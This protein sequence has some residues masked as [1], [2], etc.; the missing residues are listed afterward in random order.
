MSEK[1]RP[2]SAAPRV[3]LFDSNISDKKTSVLQA[4]REKVGNESQITTRY[5]NWEEEAKQK[6]VSDLIKEKVGE[7]K[8]PEGFF[9]SA[10]TS[11]KNVGDSTHFQKLKKF[12]GGLSMPSIKAKTYFGSEARIQFFDR[13]HTIQRQR[14]IITTQQTSEYS[15]PPEDIVNADNSEDYAFKP[16]RSDLPFE[17]SAN[18][19]IRTQSSI[20]EG[21]QFDSHMKFVVKNSSFHSKPAMQAT[22]EGS[23][24]F[25]DFTSSV[26]EISEFN[27][28]EDSFEIRLHKPT[29]DL[30]RSNTLFSPLSTSTLTSP[31]MPMPMPTA[32]RGKRPSTSNSSAMNRRKSSYKGGEAAAALSSIGNEAGLPAAVATLDTAKS[33]SKAQTM[34]ANNINNAAINTS[35][36]SSTSFRRNSS[37]YSV[38][39]DCDNFSALSAIKERVT[40]GDS[41]ASDSLDF[42]LNQS[43]DE[44]IQLVCVEDKRRRGGSIVRYKGRRLEQSSMSVSVGRDMDMDAGSVTSMLVNCRNAQGV[45]SRPKSTNPRRRGK[46]GSHSPERNID[47]SSMSVYNS[48][49]ADLSPRSRYIDGCIRKKLNPRLSLILRKSFTKCLDLQHHGIGDEMAVLFAEAIVDIPYVEALNMADNNLTDKGLSAIIDA[50]SRMKDLIDLN[51]SYNVI[52]ENAAGS[53]SSYLA[54]PSCAL[55]RLALQRADVDDMECER[56]VSSLRTNRSLTDLDLSENLVGSHEQLNTVLPDITTGA[57]AL[58]ELLTSPHCIIQTLKLG[59]VLIYI[60]CLL[61]LRER[62]IVL[63]CRL[64]YDPPGQRQ[65]IVPSGRSHED[66]NVLR[67]VVQCVGKRRRSNIRK[68]FIAESNPE[69]N[70]SRILRE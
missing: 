24:K 57:E 27:E 46:D 60:L 65:S 14:S 66:S 6:S 34:N 26:S 55:I 42:E 33:K 54:S 1:A 52:G 51:L 36:H 13:Q 47:N 35:M 5:K 67:S 8:Y 2:Y 30:A 69:G 16:S 45:F 49:S 31:A 12:P 32:F 62:F 48:S 58:A 28:A 9:P 21:S 43:E 40:I 39:S 17:L 44:P 41:F 64:E 56:I 19:I 10:S 38:D 18:I 61:S 37:Y 50:I 7:L 11:N 15:P 68:F 22:D 70:D 20:N 23:F 3:R 29:N 59:Q 4:I 53:L 25:N 63:L